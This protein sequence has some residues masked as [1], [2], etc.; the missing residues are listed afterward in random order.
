MLYRASLRLP[1]VNTDKWVQLLQAAELLLTAVEGWVYPVPVPELVLV[2]TGTVHR[3]WH[4]Y[5][6]LQL[7][8]ASSQLAGLLFLK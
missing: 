1:V 2:G 8:V 7:V 4:Y 5:F 6:G 3:Q